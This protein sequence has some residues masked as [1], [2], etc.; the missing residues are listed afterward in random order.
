MVRGRFASLA[1]PMSVRLESK[2]GRLA[3]PSGVMVVTGLEARGSTVQGGDVV[4]RLAGAR[5]GAGQGRA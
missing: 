3:V 4:P 2:S 1:E 5:C